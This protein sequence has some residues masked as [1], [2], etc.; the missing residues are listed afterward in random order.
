MSVPQSYVQESAPE[1]K[2][3]GDEKDEERNRPVYHE[4][5]PKDN[6]KFHDS[7]KEKDWE[8]FE[9]LLKKYKGQYY[10]R[11]RI[12]AKEIEKD[13]L[14]REEEEKANDEADETAEAEEE[15]TKL[16]QMRQRLPFAN[17]KELSKVEKR[18]RNEKNAKKVLP[19]FVTKKVFADPAEIVSPLLMVDS[20]GRTPLHLACLH[21]APPKTIL[22]LLFAE[23]RAS[24]MRDYSGQLP[25]HCAIKTWQEE[26]VLERIIKACPSGLKHKDNKG[27]TPLGFAVQRAIRGRPGCEEDVTE[28]PNSPFLWIYSTSD[29]EENWQF[30]QE[31]CWAK[32]NCLLRQYIDR[33]MT[34][35]P[36][37][38]GL[39]LEALE[40]GANPNTIV[41]FVTTTA[42]YLKMDDELAGA[43]IGLCIERHYNARTLEFLLENCREN[44]T[45][46]SDIVQKATK[47]HYS[48]GCYPLRDGMTP[49]GKS[50]IDWAK[51]HNRG[52]HRRS[53]I[54][55]R[56]RSSTSRRVSF[57]VGNPDD[58][59]EVDD[60]HKKKWIGMEEA[61][62]DWWEILNHLLFYSAY[63]RDY[64]SKVEPKTYHLLHAALSGPMNPP[65]LIHLLLITYPEA[66]NEQCPVYK[67]LPIHLACTRWRYDVIY[68]DSEISSLGQV[69]RHFYQSDPNQLFHRHKGS[70]PIHMALLGGQFWEF[71]RSM[72]SEHK[73]FLGM[74]DAQSRLFPFQIAALPI[75]FRNSQLLMR[76]QFNPTEWR[77]LTVTE[78]KLEH[79][80]V[81]DEQ[82]R[83]QLGTIF[84]LLRE[85]PDAIEN[86][87]VTKDPSNISRTLRSLS[88]LSIHCLSWIYEQN[89]NGEFGV[90]YDNLAALRDSILDAQILPEL[91]DWW[92]GL[93]ECIWKDSHEDTPRTTDFLLHSA[94]YNCETP[95]LV[96][97]LLIRLFPSSLAKQI[98]GTSTYPLHIAAATTSYQRQQFEIPYGMNALGLV[99]KANKEVA[100]FKSNG[101]LP[102]HICLSRGKSWKEVL[103]LIIVDPS[104]LK[105][106]DEQTGLVPFELMSSF[107]LN[108]K[109]NSWWYSTFT[110]K[111]M[112]TFRFDQL[113]TREKAKALSRARKKKELSQLNCIFELIRYRPSVLSMRCSG[114]AIENDDDSEASLNS[115]VDEGYEA[116]GGMDNWEMINDSSTGHEPRRSRDSIASIDA[117]MQQIDALYGD[118][119]APS[120]LGSWKN[121]LPTDPLAAFTKKSGSPKRK[122]VR[123]G[124]KIALFDVND[125]DLS[126]DE[127]P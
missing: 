104:S 54:A 112:K 21:K 113:S 63:G 96:I 88:D 119:A 99:L 17:K 60:D 12:Q 41:Q 10:K 71:V 78:K 83:R 93:K 122:L 107:N 103:P 3:E 81:V 8:S 80:K 20:K 127:T 51:R 13:K 86:R 126:D 87:I 84:E 59:K 1:Y 115:F 108:A 7:I 2:Y 6:S 111:Q 32:V 50:V 97:D 31:M 121:P 33:K 25:L 79:E 44:T 39:I 18:E 72:T 90:R 67:V 5:G 109:E 19:K 24:S 11:K 15:K 38:H 73:E 58:K 68:H 82:E 30:E 36:S 43:A 118:G 34:I 77:D 75:R 29:E 62:K 117:G 110:E 65:S 64:K 22:D 70:L 53:S 69:L 4:L 89:S 37:E 101:R 116:K 114:L 102:L 9:K 42:R 92:D 100:R 48:L 98:P 57:V 120:M 46:I 61:C 105:V 66:L 106:E 125:L 52:R 28:D 23:K 40:R 91:Q 95:P 27:R 16:Q 45:V 94:L 55:S 85:Y 123:R 124:T 14:R 47:A 49:F 76:C 56:R 35:I 26:H 74:R